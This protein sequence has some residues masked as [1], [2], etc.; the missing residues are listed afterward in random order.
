MKIVLVATLVIFLA[1]GV[2]AQ[3]EPATEFLLFEFMEVPDENGN[4]YWQVESFWSGIHQQRVADSSIIGWDLWSLTPSGTKQGSQ[5]LTVTIFASLKDM[6]NS[7]NSLDITSYAKKAYPDMTDEEFGGVMDMTVKSRDLAHQVLL[8]GIDKTTDD[9]QMKVGSIV[10]LDI[11]KQVAENYEEAESEIFKPW[12]Q[13]LVDDGKKAHWGL[14]KAILPV[15]ND[16][17][18]THI[19]YSFYKDMN[20]LAEFMEGFGD[21]MD[22]MTGMAVEQGL[23]TRDWREMKI[24][25]LVMIV[26]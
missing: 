7:M 4:A 17:Y 20:Q 9:Y 2:N 18:G 8:V 25:R 3:Q 12:H 11:M 15:G 21:K 22:V 16:V 23:K 14:L 5:F 10:T 26:R 6:L 24:G 19:A 1:I 13:Q